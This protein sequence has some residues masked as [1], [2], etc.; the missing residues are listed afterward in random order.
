MNNYKIVEINES[1]ISSLQPLADE[2]LADGDKFIQKTIDEWRNNTNTFS[3]EGEKFWAI[4]IE[5]EYIACGGLN[6]DPYIEEKSMGRVR[7]VYVLKKYRRQ[8]YSKI[9]LTLIIEQAKKHFT[10]LRLS[11]HNPI[12]ASLYESLGF[13]KVDEH[14]ATHI[15]RNLTA[16]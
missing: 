4:T 14:K 3:K 7:H 8:G 6:Q 15:I 13:K 11:T 12:A 9:L 5:N 1:N 16:D 10:S 2:A